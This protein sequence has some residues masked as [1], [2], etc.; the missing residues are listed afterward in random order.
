MKPKLHPGQFQ[1]N[2]EVQGLF[3]DSGK[4]QHS[5]RE[6]IVRFKITKFICCLR[7]F[8]KLFEVF[9]E[10]DRFAS[11]SKNVAYITFTLFWQWEV[12]NWSFYRLWLSFLTENLSFQMNPRPLQWSAEGTHVERASKLKKWK[13]FN[14]FNSITFKT[15]LL[16]KRQRRPWLRYVKNSWIMILLLIH[17]LLLAKAFHDKK[18]VPIKKVRSGDDKWRIGPRGRLTFVAEFYS[19]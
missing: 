13:K 18:H 5:W 6:T 19:F 9:V 12:G 3:Y 15:H 17:L 14:I 16:N 2:W 1:Y 8:A 11:Y 4:N 10:L 7:S